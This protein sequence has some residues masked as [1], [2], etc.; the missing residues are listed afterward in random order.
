MT[1]QILSNPSQGRVIPCATPPHSVETE[2]ALL[3]SMVLDT[4]MIPI[5]QAILFDAYDFYKPAN[6]AIYLAITDL[7]QKRKPV[8]VLTLQDWLRERGKLDLVGGVDYLLAVVDS[9]PSA[10]LADHYA[11]KV[12]E[13]AD[14]RRLIQHAEALVTDAYDGSVDLEHLVERCRHAA[15]YPNRKARTA[16]L[17]ALT[18]LA[19]VEPKTVQWLWRQRIARGKLTILAGEPG[20]GKSTITL[21]IT[22]RVSAARG[23]PDCDDQD[24]PANVIL[25][26]A[27][28]DAAD[29]TLP[30]L[31]AAGADRGRIHIMSAVHMDP[32]NPEAIS[33]FTLTKNL[34]ALEAAIMQLSPA[35]VVIDPVT[36]YLGGT[37]SHKNADVR[38]LLAPLAALAGK[39][40]VAILIVS[41]LNKSAGASAMSRVTGSG[42]FVAA[43]RAAWVVAKD[44]EDPTGGRRLFL[45]AKNNLGR[46]S[47][48]LAYT[49]EDRGG[50]AGVRWDD[51][52]V[53]VSADSALA[54][55]PE[56]F[57]P[58][59][60]RRD[61]AEEWLRTQL[62]G[63][64]QAAKDL[65][66]A[67]TQGECI[68]RAT[69]E[70]A[71]AHLGIKAY[72]PGKNTGPWFWKLA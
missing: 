72:R 65:I 52:P 61:A 17:P 51:E 68:P 13:Y 32:E 25:L 63:G 60:A 48:G 37:D 57:G 15:D 23:W 6:S 39:Y 2:A 64:P 70:R 29:T 20:L 21:D 3:G 14:R 10:V 50:V 7:H 62:A 35:L 18:C 40:N 55:S 4:A 26:S 19:D 11:R 69:L 8:E 59:P 5:V 56:S 47:S 27:E 16:Q 1:S 34:P 31:I 9:V 24:E 66:E 12:K 30:R 44:K 43:A 46:D 33:S 41:H 28:D 38:A 42:A 36:A 54:E 58:K 53:T 71:K 45:P 67:A 22:A 49:L